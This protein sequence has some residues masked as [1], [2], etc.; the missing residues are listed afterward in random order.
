MMLPSPNARGSDAVHALKIFML[1][2]CGPDELIA[3]NA[4][5]FTKSHDYLAFCA[6]RGIETGYAPEYSP[7][8]NSA[9]EAKWKHWAEE[10]KTTGSRD[11]DLTVYDH[12]W[13]QNNKGVP[14]YA[15]AS[16]VSL[17]TGKGVSD[18]HALRAEVRRVRRAADALVRPNAPT[19]DVGERVDLWKP[20]P[21][22]MAVPFCD[23]FVIRT[24]HPTYWVKDAEGREC[25]AS[26]RRLRKIPPDPFSTE[27]KKVEGHQDDADL[28]DDVAEL[29]QDSDD[30]AD[31]DLSFPD[32]GMLASLKAGDFILYRDGGMVY[33]GYLMRLLSDTVEFHEAVFK[34]KGRRI[35][36]EKT[37]ISRDG[38]IAQ[39]NYRP[40][41]SEPVV[42]KVDP[43]T[44][45]R[46][47]VL[48]TGSLLPVNDELPNV[49]VT[50]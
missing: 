1:N 41:D 46:S 49:V 5:A 28:S 23:G 50:K 21:T 29:K 42:Y 31:D 11:W 4:L 9:I 10:A 37:W 43:V 36:A 13:E 2:G 3:D 44:I 32:P 35:K 17:E 8:G 19:F 26:V 18:V 14:A 40:K 39:S 48:E 25:R 12:C 7:Q 30:E 22:K 38:V 34:K 15:G 16:A 33:G 45:L 24:K 47:V 6:R 20:P 27:E